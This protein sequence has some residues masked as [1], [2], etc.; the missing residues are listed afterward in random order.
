MEVLLDDTKFSNDLLNLI[1][2]I[3]QINYIKTKHYN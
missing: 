1:K 2:G 3:A